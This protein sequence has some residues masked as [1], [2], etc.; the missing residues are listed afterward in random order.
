[1]AA[2]Q[3]EERDLVTAF[4]ERYV[5]YRRRTPMLLP[6]LWAAPRQS[7]APPPSGQSRSA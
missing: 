6:R 3:L 5:E 1:L 7:A 2:I 4:G